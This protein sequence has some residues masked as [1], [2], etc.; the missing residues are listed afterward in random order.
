LSCGKREAKVRKARQSQV[1]SKLKRRTYSA[2]SAKSVD[3]QR[4]IAVIHG[5]VAQV[6]AEQ[7]ERRIGQKVRT[8]RNSSRR[9]FRGNTGT[10]ADADTDE[11]MINEDEAEAGNRTTTELDNTTPGTRA[12]SVTTF[13]RLDSF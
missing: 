2:I 11:A 7:M 4:K 8:I 10:A 3:T 12:T 1:F 13:K 9:D 6:E 5:K